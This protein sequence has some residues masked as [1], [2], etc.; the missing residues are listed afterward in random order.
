LQLAVDIATLN[1]KVVLADRINGK[2]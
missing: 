2:L 1:G